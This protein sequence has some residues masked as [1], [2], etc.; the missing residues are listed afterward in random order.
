MMRSA[1]AGSR[2]KTFLWV[3]LAL[4]AITLV[5]FAL[6]DYGNFVGYDEW[7]HAY[8][9]SRGSTIYA[10][11]PLSALALFLTY[12]FTGVN[13]FAS[14]AVNLGVRLVEAILIYLIMDRLKPR[15]RALAFLSAALFLVFVVPDWYTI[16]SLQARS[17]HSGNLLAT[18]ATLYL[19]TRFL[20]EDGI[21]WLILALA[22]AAVAVLIREACVPLLGGFA[23]MVFL[24]QRKFTRRRIVFV[25]LFLL[26]VAGASLHY[27]LPLIGLAPKLYA[28]G[29]Y[30]DLNP[31][32]MINATWTQFH[33]AF[34]QLA[35][36]RIDFLAQNR[37]AEMLTAGVLIVCV[38]VARHRLPTEPTQDTFAGYA[39]WV[40]FGI[41]LAWLGFAAFLPTG[42][43]TALDRVQNLS[44]IGEAIALASI[45]RMFSTLPAR[46]N[47]RHAVEATGLALI[48]I[49]STSM[50][51]TVQNELYSY[52]LTWDTEAVFVRSLANLTPQ[53]KENTLFFYVENPDLPETPFLAG[54]GFQYAMRYLYEDRAVG[55]IDRDKLWFH[56]WVISDS[57]IEITPDPALV[58]T[59]FV[60]AKHSR[61]RWDEIIFIA[62]DREARVRILEQL[63]ETYYT[64][65]RAAQYDPYARIE[66]GFITPRIRELL[67]PIQ[68][69]QPILLP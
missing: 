15:D 9:A 2:T 14:H 43:S 47:F 27:V 44:T 36:G 16:L 11:R 55:L 59:G 32:R 40:T 4:T 45:V 62:K 8:T 34:S 12:P 63:P 48:A 39:L 52:N 51:S 35:L 25:A 58:A 41:V 46:A 6:V 61:H 20:E 1:S 3:V 54:F 19:V 18:L 56:D 53:V 69:V 67:P 13:P 50:V 7:P 42:L 23:V 24:S 28:T 30:Q 49:L 33:F 57:G 60:G 64:P 17:D 26:A 5:A 68:S 37:L 10:G 65:E 22:L 21:V 38:V 29:L 66:R 31:L